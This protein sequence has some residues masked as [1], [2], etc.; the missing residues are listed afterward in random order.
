MISKEKKTAIMNEYA[1]T[2]GD[3]GSPEVQVAV[4]TARIQELTD[5]LKDNP[6]DHHSRRGMLKMVGQRRG[7]LEY[8]KK[9]EELK[10]YDKDDKS[11]TV[12]GD[13]VEDNITVIDT[14]QDA[15]A[16]EKAYD[17]AL[18]PF[19]L[20]ENSEKGQIIEGTDSVVNSANKNYC[21]KIDTDKQGNPLFGD[22]IITKRTLT[23][24]NIHDFVSYEGDIF[25]DQENSNLWV[26]GNLAGDSTAYGIWVKINSDNSLF[27][28]IKI[29]AVSPLD[30]EENMESEYDKEIGDNRKIS[31]NTSEKI[32]SVGQKIIFELYKDNVSCSEFYTQTV[33]VDTKAPTVTFEELVENNAAF[34]ASH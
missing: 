9:K 25:T 3:T 7:L 32:D 33:Y 27:D 19:I 34:K 24:S 5:H 22:L 8:L 14:K 31:F 26:R 6:K 4:L 21:Y 15:L 18:K 12:D 13:K 20:D 1:R 29:T 11:G 16:Q 30:S 10:A 17:N 28:A 23:N 2:P